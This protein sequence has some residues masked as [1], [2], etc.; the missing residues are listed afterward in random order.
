MDIEGNLARFSTEEQAAT[1]YPEEMLLAKVDVTDLLDDSYARIHGLE[2][3]QA[4]DDDEI[5]QSER[6]SI[7]PQLMRE[8][9]KLQIRQAIAE[10]ITA[11]E[12]EDYLKGPQAL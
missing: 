6:G 3:M 1:G 2:Q 9:K 4:M 8:M 10:R 5:T 12:C 7:G 11:H